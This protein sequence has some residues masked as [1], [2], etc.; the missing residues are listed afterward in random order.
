MQI[1]ADT[2]FIYV[3]GFNSS[4]QSF[5]AQQTLELFRQRGVEDQLSIPKLSHFPAEAMVQLKELVEASERAVLIG[6]SLGGFYSTWLTEHYAQARAVLVNPAVAP[7]KLLEGML[8]FTENYYSG[9]RYELTQSHMDQLKV[10]YLPEVTHPERLLLLQQEGDE[11]L[12]YRDAVGYY[13]TSPQ[14]VQPGGS[15][16]FD[17]FE[18]VLPLIMDFA[19]GQIDTS[20]LTT[21]ADLGD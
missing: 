7:H 1:P 6:S 8:G 21:Q 20:L 11:T 12:D 16:A 3:H 2:R 18:T 15:H 17:N 10:L 19:T 5:K 4:P 13:K 14:I 9:E